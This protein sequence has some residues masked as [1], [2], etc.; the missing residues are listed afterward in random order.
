MPLRTGRFLHPREHPPA[1]VHASKRCRIV[2][3]VF[4]PFVAISFS[5]TAGDAGFGTVAEV[6]TGAA[7]NIFCFRSAA[8]CAAMLSQA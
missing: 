3:E 7:F 4:G 6:R 2:C 1:F 5:G 8:H